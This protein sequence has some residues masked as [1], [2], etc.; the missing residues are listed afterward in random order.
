MGVILLKGICFMN[1]MQFGKSYKKISLHPVVSSHPQFSLNF[2]PKFSGSD[3]KSALL[4]NAARSHSLP[5][6]IRRQSLPTL[7]L[8]EAL[9]IYPFRSYR[10]QQS[11]NQWEVYTEPGQGGQLAEALGRLSIIKASQMLIKMS[12]GYCRY[13]HGT[14][15]P[16]FRAAKDAAPTKAFL[17]LEMPVKSKEWAVEEACHGKHSWPEDKGSTGRRFG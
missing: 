9:L 16:P 10:Q 13:S 15:G 12:S 2:T 4:G 14:P 11:P 7:S 6:R 1:S 3:G 5:L 17:C 8:L